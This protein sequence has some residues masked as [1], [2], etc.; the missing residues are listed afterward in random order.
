MVGEGGRKGPSKASAGDSGL[1]P[2]MVSSP[3][4]VGG[5]EVMATTL[6]SRWTE[7]VSHESN[8]LSIE[9]ASPAGKHGK[10]IDDLAD[11]LTSLILD[12]PGPTRVVDDLLLL[13]GPREVGVRG[14]ECSVTS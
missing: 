1:L 14:G 6:I 2:G 9:V 11:P 12:E 10:S 8:A 5:E 3:E 7:E 13:E 4:R